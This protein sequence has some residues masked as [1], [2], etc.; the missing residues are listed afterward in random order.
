[1]I[2]LPCS[3]YGRGVAAGALGAGAIAALL[4]WGAARAPLPD[5]DELLPPRAIAPDL[6]DQ[7]LVAKGSTVACDALMRMVERARL[8]ADERKDRPA[9]IMEK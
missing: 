5:V 1:M 4:S 8:A 7:C 9:T 2:L 3:P 6:Y